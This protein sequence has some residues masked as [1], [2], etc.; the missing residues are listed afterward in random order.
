MEDQGE[1]KR[2]YT[3]FRDVIKQAGGL[4]YVFEFEFLLALALSVTA[5]FTTLYFDSE[6][7][8]L[9]ELM[10]LFIATSGALLGFII[11]A[12]AFI[13]TAG[14]SGFR[15]SFAYSKYYSQMKVDFT[16][17]PILGG[18][19]I[20]TSTFSILIL[21]NVS[22]MLGKILFMCDLFLFSWTILMVVVLIGSA[23]RTLGDFVIRT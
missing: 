16:L 3:P 13:L 23:I 6:Q 15:E 2:I 11:A 17:T 12:Y 5:F 20:V 7:S 19:C 1:E 21:G 10:K 18:L 22:G 4:K 14:T 9:I 8:I